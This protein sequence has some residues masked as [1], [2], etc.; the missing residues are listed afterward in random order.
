MKI[1]S[2]SY[3]L[4]GGFANDPFT[5]FYITEAEGTSDVEPKAQEETGGDVATKD[6]ADAVE[7]EEKEDGK[8]DT[9]E[10]IGDY[11]SKLKKLT[12]DF[13]SK[14]KIA[15][16]S[17]KEANNILEDIEKIADN[18]EVTFATDDADLELKDLIKFS[19]RLM[20]I[21]NEANKILETEEPEETETK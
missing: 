14:I 1:P 10:K 4:L 21:F 12:D 19:E 5:R 2:T 18:S 11:K 6:T 16:D 3:T 7:D 20:V 17:F 15:V 8:E 9:E 13:K